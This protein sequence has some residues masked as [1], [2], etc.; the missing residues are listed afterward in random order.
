MSDFILN[1]TGLD[2]TFK[3]FSS[4]TVSGS[5]TT[6]FV[7]K[8]VSAFTV[9]DS[10]IFDD[11]MA[12][13]VFNSTP[14]TK[15]HIGSATILGVVPPGGSGGNPIPACL[16]SIIE[17]S[18]GSVGVP[19]YG[20]GSTV[21]FTA[22]V[23]RPYGYVS[24]SV[25]TGAGTGTL[26]STG[27]AA[28]VEHAAPGLG[29]TLDLATGMVSAIIL[30]GSGDITE[31]RAIDVL[32]VDF[33]FGTIENAYGF[34]VGSGTISG[35]NKWAIYI[36]DSSI[37]NYFAGNIG[38]D[39]PFPLEAL[40][41][42]P[43]NNIVIEMPQITGEISVATTGGFYTPGENI[44]YII[45][46]V[47]Y[48]GDEGA[49]SSVIGGSLPF[50]QTA[51]SLSWTPVQGA[52]KYRIYR[53]DPVGAGFDDYFETINTSFLDVGMS[54]VGPAYTPG[55]PSGLD[56]AYMTYLN[57]GPGG[58]YIGNDLVVNE[59]I[60]VRGN[61]FKISPLLSNADLWIVP[62]G[63]GALQ[64]DSGGN[65]R[66]IYANDFQRL[67][68]LVTQVASG[69]NSF[70]AGGENNTA[71]GLR[72]YAEGNG[73][74]AS[75]TNSHAEGGINVASGTDSHVEGG[76][77]LASGANSHAEGSAC[78]ASGPSSHAEGAGSFATVTSAHAEGSFTD[79]IGSSSHSEGNT[80]LASG[81]ASH[82]EGTSTTASGHSSHAGGNTSTASGV[83]S[84]V[85]GNAS[86]AS[87]EDSFA[88]GP[89]ALADLRNQYAHGSFTVLK[90]QYTRTI[91]FHS[92]STLSGLPAAGVIVELTL[93][94]VTA[95][96]ANWYK[97]RT[98]TN[99]NIDLQVNF[100]YNSTFTGIDSNYYW[101]R[102]F[103]V[104][105]KGGICSII[106]DVANTLDITDN[107]I[108]IILIISADDSDN[109][110]KIEVDTSAVLLSTDHNYSGIAVINA[111]E[112]KEF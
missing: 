76:G 85:H 49:I 102:N 105:N 31:A 48:K 101:Q 33:G 74:T 83:T 111:V 100:R 65:Q 63:T 10:N 86:V 7:T 21:Q 8:F 66:G 34:Y 98:D 27:F 29:D 61:V 14:A 89:Q 42:G 15:F 43:N 60:N 28:L 82:S 26:L 35:T 84:F 2:L 73:N 94:G 50:S 96:I 99:Y 109:R 103:I 16:F 64:T 75:G 88:H 20:A 57:S 6:N 112:N 18:V 81:A 19:F 17:T 59:D 79:A 30:T 32:I 56:N 39:E 92:G 41:V 77:S 71:I 46:A 38:I 4:G 80:T 3:E 25:T 5:G 53:N 37:N 45:T 52:F 107:D 51:W 78:T 108:G 70:I 54:G 13:G 91:M 12:I 1:K 55:S 67:R 47:D 104:K 90:F 44:T 62:L 106:G 72:S 93:D 11:G 69:N 110:L 23:G 97:L 40:H 24:A 22:N 87:A 36:D 9:G 68:T 95:V 58:S